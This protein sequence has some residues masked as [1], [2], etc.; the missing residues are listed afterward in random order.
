[1][2]P[3]RYLRW[4]TLLGI[5]PFP[6]PV[7]V[8]P[9][10]RCATPLVRGRVPPIRSGRL[11]SSLPRSTV[12]GAC[13][14]PPFRTV[15]RKGLSI[16]GFPSRGI[17]LLG[18]FLVGTLLGPILAPD[19]AGAGLIEERKQRQSCFGCH[20]AP[21]GTTRFERDAET[22]EM[23]EVGIDWT[24]YGHGVHQEV[25]CQ[26]C[27]TKGFATYPHS[28]KKTYTCMGCHARETT[29]NPTGE[30]AT[31]RERALKFEEWEAEFL[32]T[33]HYTEH[34]REAHFPQHRKRAIDH[35]GEDYFKCEQCHDPHY[36]PLAEDMASVDEIMDTHNRWCVRCHS[37]EAEKTLAPEF[38]PRLL[39]G[40]EAAPVP[41]DLKGKETKTPPLAD[42]ADPS[43]KAEHAYLPHPGAHLRKTRCIEC[44]TSNENPV[45]HELLVENAEKGCATCH[46]QDS[47][48]LSTLYRHRAPLPKIGWQAQHSFFLKTGYELEEDPDGT[49]TAGSPEGKGEHPPTKGLDRYAGPRL[50]FVNATILEDSYVMGSTRNTALDWLAYVLVGVAL[51][52]VLMH[53]LL[54]LLRGIFLRD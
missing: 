44:H 24:R 39:I 12:D 51:A 18:W 53:A 37:A 48:L 20:S 50:G 47:V 38:D 45:S 27:H 31:G 25:E 15:R 10:R 22:G 21:E 23:Q 28:D 43:L 41:E 54:R 1:M 33:V 36:F 26:E 34:G 9:F 8:S 7:G 49:G 16:K 29:D 40:G 42:P 14:E 5:L 3:V 30:K 13:T 4:H 11:S 46:N 35:E 52:F 19:E 32:D 17:A 2:A 6:Y